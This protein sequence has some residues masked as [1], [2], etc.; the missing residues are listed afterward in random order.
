M[1]FCTA[2][3]CM[4][5]RIQ[6]PMRKYLIDHY[7]VEY[8]DAIT[9]PGPNRILAM[10]DDPVFIE[11]ITRCLRVSLNAHDSVGFA[12]V[13]HDDCAGNPVPR[14]VQEEHTKAA[15]AWVRA[16]APDVPVIGLWVDTEG[17]VTE[18]DV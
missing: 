15:A 8:V 11:A 9:A 7:G 17:I 12:V 2:I 1:N 13:G 18:L 5:G 6:R 10:Q 16:Q 14:A 4:D 3:V